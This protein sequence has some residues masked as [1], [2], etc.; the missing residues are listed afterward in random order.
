MNST[1]LLYAARS[2]TEIR[3]SC[4]EERSCIVVLCDGSRFLS[5]E[6]WECEGPVL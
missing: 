3:V 6:V 5:F 2:P 1:D 4:R